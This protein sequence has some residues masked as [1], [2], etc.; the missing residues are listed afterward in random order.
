VI[1]AGPG[2]ADRFCGKVQCVTATDRKSQVKVVGNHWFIQAGPRF[3]S[4]ILSFPRLLY[5]ELGGPVS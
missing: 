5:M 3:A 4:G 1:S 2:G